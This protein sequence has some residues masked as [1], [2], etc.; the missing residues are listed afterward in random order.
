MAMFVLDTP[1]NRQRGALEAFL[2]RTQK[3]AE[4]AILHHQ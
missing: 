3:A 4:N 2:P 1:Q